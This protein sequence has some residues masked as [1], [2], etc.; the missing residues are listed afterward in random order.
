MPKMNPYQIAQ[1]QFDDA[2]KYLPDLSDG[3]KTYLRQTDRSL[4]VRFSIEM[5]DGSVQSFVGYRMMHSRVRGPGKGGIRYHPEVDR[6][7]VKALASWMTW[8]NAIMDVPFG[9]AKGA[10]VCDPKSMSKRELYKLTRK[11]VL[12][13]GEN[14]G[15]YV[16]VPAP[17]L[18]TNAQT[19]AWIYDTYDRHHPGRNNLPAVTGKPVHI[20]GSLGREEATGRGLVDCLLATINELDI[21]CG[22]RVAI[23]GFGNV[24]SVV[25]KMLDSHDYHI[26][27]VSDSQGGLYAPGGLNVHRLLEA[28]DIYGTVDR[29]QYGEG[30]VITNEEL[31]EL[32]VDILIPAALGGQITADNADKIKA[33]IIVEAANG[34][35]TPEADTI[36]A[37]KEI[38]VLPDILANA[39]G[40]TVSY[41]EWVQN[42]ENQ[43]WSVQLVNEKLM[44]KMQCA[45]HEV[46][47]LY[48]R[49]QTENPGVSLR[50]AAFVLGIDRVAQVALDRSIWP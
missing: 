50:T 26:V 33:S 11:F 39:G 14:I 9:G 35:T 2:V 46:C 23:Q 40:V 43:R 12:E 18:G 37:G 25:A 30:I 8:K 21:G 15:P 6:E 47:H 42:M 3:L 28:K 44:N 36:L 45:T 41:Y 13:L 31:L 24:G 1:Q 5:D 17:D 7:E 10:I 4:S 19:M 32:D 16:D 27:A 20:G 34:P 38:V 29:D 48:R 22:R 49:L